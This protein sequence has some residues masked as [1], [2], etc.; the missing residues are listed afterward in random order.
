MSY[1]L[2]SWILTGPLKATVKTL[3]IA[4]LLMFL[5]TPRRL[6]VTLR[7]LLY[8]SINISGPKNFLRLGSNK[9]WR[10]SWPSKRSVVMRTQVLKAP[11]VE[12]PSMWDQESQ[13]D[14]EPAP[15][16]LKLPAKTL[17]LVLGPAKDVERAR[18][19]M[20]ARPLQTISLSLRRLLTQV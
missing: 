4:F 19:P 9:I 2:Q 11:R 13:A 10:N 5:I 6:H 12:R 7:N 3:Q 18:K 8:S 1:L 14:A 17:A 20:Q 15:K 16:K